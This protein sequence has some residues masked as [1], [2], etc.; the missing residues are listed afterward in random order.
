MASSGGGGDALVPIYASGQDRQVKQTIV[1]TLFARS[2]AKALVDLA[3]NEK[4][5]EMKKIIV[6]FLSTMKG[7]EATVSAGE[8]VHQDGRYG[9]APKADLSCGGHTSAQACV[10][11]ARRDRVAGHGIRTS[12]YPPRRPWEREQWMTT[13]AWYPS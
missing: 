10:S 3:R 11:T 12:C 13:R 8:R 7:K 5:P 2:N 4:D 9:D 6:R 1:E